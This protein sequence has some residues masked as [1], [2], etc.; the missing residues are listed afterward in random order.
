LDFP[1]SQNPNTS[2]EL[3]SGNQILVSG[4]EAKRNANDS[5]IVTPSLTIDTT[6]NYDAIFRGG[7]FSK[8]L[9]IIIPPAYTSS[10]NI[11][12]RF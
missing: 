7:H 1:K 8:T 6:S 5:G 4:N 3:I 12:T 9:G 2:A 10:H 11:A